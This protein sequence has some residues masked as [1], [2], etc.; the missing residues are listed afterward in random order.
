MYTKNIRIWALGLNKALYKHEE[1]E[2]HHLWSVRGQPIENENWY[3]FNFL[4]YRL[5]N[6]PCCVCDISFDSYSYPRLCHQTT[7]LIFAPKR[8]AP[9]TPKT[10]AL[11]N[12]RPICSLNTMFFHSTIPRMRKRRWTTVGKPCLDDRRPCEATILFRAISA[13]IM[14]R[15]APSPSPQWFGQIDCPVWVEAV[16]PQSEQTK[17]YKGT[18]ESWVYFSLGKMSI[19]TTVPLFMKAAVRDVISSPKPLLALRELLKN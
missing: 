6:T 17:S 2:A 11:Q 7:I 16:Q 1:K 15:R 10:E 19:A 4:R 5:W 8:N 3:S 12:Y 9:A 18:T 14:R 13:I